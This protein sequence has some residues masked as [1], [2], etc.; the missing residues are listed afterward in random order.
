MLRR[1]EIVEGATLK[2]RVA[3]SFFWWAG[4]GKGVD[5]K[6][7]PVNFRLKGLLVARFGTCFDAGLATGINSTQLSAII[8]GRRPITDGQRAALERV[9]GKQAIEEALREEDQEQGR[10]A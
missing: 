10:S 9:L 4:G 1:P 7:R 6:M 3:P 8:N 5:R 2:K